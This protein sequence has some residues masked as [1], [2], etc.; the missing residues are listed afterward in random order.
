MAISVNTVWECRQG[1][2]S[3]SNGGAF[4]AGAAG[5]D[6]SQ[7]NAAQVVINNST[8]TTSITANVITFTAGYTPTAADVGNLV[9]MTAGT[10]VTVGWYQITAQTA[11]TWTVT[12]TVALPT[13]GTTTNATGNM[14][15]ALLTLATLASAMISQNIGWC[16]GA[17][18]STA[19]TTFAQ[20][21]TPSGV[22]PLRVVGY[23]TTRGDTGHATLTL[24]TNINLTGLL[25]SGGGVRFENFDVDCAGLGNS[26]GIN[27]QGLY[28]M[29][30]N[31]KVSNFTFK[32]ILMTGAASEALFCEVT[33][34]TSAASWAMALGTP[35]TKCANCHIHDNACSGVVGGNNC[36][37]VNCLIVNNTGATSDGV[38]IDYDSI[39][40]G[41]TIHGNGRYGMQLTSST[42]T[43]ITW[44]NNLIS[45][46]G[47]AGA[48]SATP[49]LPAAPEYDGNG[50]YNNGAGG[51]VHRT[52]L[53]SVAGIYV[54]NPYTNIHDVIL[55]A[56]PYVGP[57]TGGATANFGLN[58]TA[59]GG[60][61]CRGAGVFNTWPGM[62]ATVGK[63]D[64]GA[65]QHADPANKAGIIVAA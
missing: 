55:T 8:I 14:G 54:L 41:N 21:T 36:N 27:T 33:A 22:P 25:S 28:S 46:N 19:T 18:T 5:T 20:S 57:T 4:V 42:Q 31:C 32:G 60:A 65:V 45:G 7:Q 44:F 53:D 38:R 48:F 58:T 34:G 24:Q 9:K 56:S 51:T 1:L 11:T 35:D 17:F 12:G 26:I 10:N 15:G 39:V 2:G 47:T 3:D 16:K 6:R 62:T 43:A 13:S 49:A 61:A 63:A 37:I 29:V 23:G 52:N 30:L 40:E 50:Y 64:L 59:G